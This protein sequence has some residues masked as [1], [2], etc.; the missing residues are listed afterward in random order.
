MITEQV[1]NVNRRMRGDEGWTFIETIIVLFII[2]ILTGSVGF[3]GVRYVEKAR[4]VS[5]AAQIET[6]QFALDIYYLDCT[7]YPTESQG[8]QALYTLPSLEPVPAGWDGP[9]ITRP[10]FED[11]WGQPL[12]YTNG[13]YN[14]I[15]I[16]SY[17]PDQRYGGEG[18]SDD[19]RSR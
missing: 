7:A 5:A 2:L 9:Y 19:I 6:L 8:L 11:P 17:G 14:G 18:R 16:V 15:T 3:M 4:I 10:D 12:R 13:E 1:D